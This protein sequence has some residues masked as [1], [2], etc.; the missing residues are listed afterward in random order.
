M[1]RCVFAALIVVSAMPVAAV[2]GEARAQF[3]VTAHVT[4][5][6][7]IES[8]VQPEQFAVSAED[9]DRGYVD[10]AAVYRVSSN[11]PAGY[12][13]RLVPRV[14]LTRA[15]EVN[16]FASPVIVRDDVVDV[17]QPAALRPQDLRLS[18]RLLLDAAA[19]PGTYEWPV[20]LAAYAL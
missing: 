15:I 18:L 16:G 11:D 13:V 2:A 10:L 19:V 9:V 12:L 7:S 1:R 6:A 20:Q 5:R 3:T 14:G 8:I 17:S 4:P